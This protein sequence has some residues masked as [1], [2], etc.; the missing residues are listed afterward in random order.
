MSSHYTFQLLTLSNASIM[1]W[2]PTIVHVYASDTLALFVILVTAESTWKVMKITTPRKLLTIQ[3]DIPVHSL[4][5]HDAWYGFM[6]Y[7]YTLAL[8]SHY[9]STR[10]SCDKHKKISLAS[11]LLFLCNCNHY[12]GSD[13]EC[14]YSVRLYKSSPSLLFNLA[15]FTIC[16][17]HSL[18]LKVLQY[19]FDYMS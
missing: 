19:C 9:T 4:L 2:T 8:Y 12:V 10:S 3:C 16:R 6:A 7:H 18:Y 11:F 13:S 17:L 1:L 15:V 5:L 14:K